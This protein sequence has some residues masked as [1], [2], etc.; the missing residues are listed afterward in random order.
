MTEERLDGGQHD[1]V[2]TLLPLLALFDDLEQQAEGLELERRDAEV[3]DRLRDE[4]AEVDLAAR[5]HASVGARVVLTVAGPGAAGGTVGGEE[6]RGTLVRVGADW[7]LLAV[8]GR[9]LLVRT[10]TVVLA[11]GLSERALLAEARPVL[12]RLRLT[13]CLRR[14]AEDGERQRLRLVDGSVRTGEL[15]RVGAD[16]VELWDDQG[17]VQ[18]PLPALVWVRCD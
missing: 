5:L 3:A 12:S 18:V 7:L 16:F 13:A 1:A 6:V 10:E 9:E 11:R 17:V 15:G 4:Y 2:E 14:L 8:D